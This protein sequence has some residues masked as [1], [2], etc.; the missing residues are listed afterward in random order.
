MRRGMAGLAVL[1][2][3]GLW[4]L[5]PATGRAAEEKAG[6]PQPPAAEGT[7][8]EVPQVPDQPPKAA[9]EPAPL[10]PAVGE[11][12]LYP[13][14][15]V[16][17]VAK[18]DTLWDLSGKYLGTPWRWPELWERNR[19]L[20]NPHYIY[21]G[22]RVEI[23]PAAPKDYLMEVAPAPEPARE[24]A[25]VAALPA[26]PPAEPAPAAP[27]RPAPGPPVLGIAPNDFVRG[28]EFLLR[29]PEGI[30]RI[31]GGEEPRVAFSEGDRIHLALEKEIPPGQ[32]L[33]A[34]R[35]RKPETLPA[36]GPGTGYVRY[37]V[38]IVQVTGRQDGLHE[39][40]VR[41]S[42]EDLNVLCLL[43]EEIP[44]YAPVVLREEG[45]G[46]E[47]FVLAGRSENQDLAEGDFVYLN[48]GED[49]GIRT[50]DVFGIY[51]RALDVTWQEG[52]RATG[53]RVPVA[54]AVVVKVL[55]E[56]S[57]AYVQ[58]SSFSFL[59]G[60]IARRGPLPKDR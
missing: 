18:G 34:Y 58:D 51:V 47:T 44:S 25:E 29:R 23:F 6:G 42:F 20:S 57:T 45:D 52:V 37:L 27:E 12:A 30:G 7:V 49:R 31:V 3:S 40:V 8:P 55:P 2:I 24:E 35:V 33:G 19:F 59:A 14:G 11:P 10:S 13:E 15:L 26:G 32:I 21:P 53:A 43:S 48:G 39:A 17:D 22:I 54:K 56:S 4:I 50:G 46:M 5:L 36:G 9:P 28:G 41:K 60:A 38:G 16:H 1:V